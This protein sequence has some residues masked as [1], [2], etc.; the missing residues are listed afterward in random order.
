M[1]GNRIA[2][3]RINAG[4]ASQAEFAKALGVSR[5][6]VGQWESHRKPPGRDN[7][8]KIAQLTAVDP[9]YLAGQSN[10]PRM[11]VIVDDPLIVR[12]V[13]R[14]Q[15]LSRGQQKNLAELLDQVLPTTNVR[16]KT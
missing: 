2:K 10:D 16:E 7:L 14:L 9:R 1:L 6:L 12:I 13:L 8:L 3:A 5:G 4:Y 11:S 15:R